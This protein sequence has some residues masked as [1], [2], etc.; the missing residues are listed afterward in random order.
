MANGYIIETLLK[1]CI[2]LTTGYQATY[3]MSNEPQQKDN[4]YSVL[5]ANKPKPDHPNRGRPNLLSNKVVFTTR[6][7]RT[8]HMY[9]CRSDLFFH[10]T[11]L[12]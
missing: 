2:T 5:Q 8:H 6:P 7:L 12:S 10:L 11:R 9:A 1:L 3:E 4:L